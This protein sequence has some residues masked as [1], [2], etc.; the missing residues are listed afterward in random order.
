L[1]GATA[2]AILAFQAKSIGGV[3]YI[4]H[5]GLGWPVLV[6][7]YAAAI[8]FIISFGALRK[9]RFAYELARVT[10]WLL[11]LP[12]GAILLFGLKSG[13]EL[14]ILAGLA[15]ILFTILNLTRAFEKDV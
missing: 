15:G 13:D 12:F 3:E 10:S 5:V 1:I 4:I 8:S 2:L 11:L 9:Q 14:F 7:I 6:E